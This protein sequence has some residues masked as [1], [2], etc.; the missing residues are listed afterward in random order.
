[1]RKD[2]PRHYCDSLRLI[3]QNMTSIGAENLRT[4][5]IEMASEQIYYP[6]ILIEYVWNRQN[7]TGLKDDSL[8][9]EINPE[10]LSTKQLEMTVEKSDINIIIN[11]CHE[12]DQ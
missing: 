1:M 9:M 3:L 2:R 4:A 12:V 11:L 7:W 5:I 10:G 6:Q 8:N